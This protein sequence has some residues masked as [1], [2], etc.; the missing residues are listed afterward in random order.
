M[1]TIL[2]A[3]LALALCACTA[4]A[5]QAPGVQRTLLQRIDLGDGRELVM[6]L[7]EVAPGAAIGR[8][9][10]FGIETGYALA[11]QSLM[12][13]DGEAPR[14]LRAGESYAIP[15]GRVHDARAI[16]GAAKVLAIYVVEKGKPL[17]TPA[18]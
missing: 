6:G 1:T 16:G 14:M 15:A 10:H 8:H 9:S 11:G 5:A 4:T 18:K 17:S 12:S 7:A 2:R 3:S 13:V